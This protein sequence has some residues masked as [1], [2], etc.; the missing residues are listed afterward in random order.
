MDSRAAIRRWKCFLP[1]RQKSVGSE[2]FSCCFSFSE[3]ALCSG[4]DTRGH[5]LRA[6]GSTVSGH[7]ARAREDRRET[8][9]RCHRPDNPIPIGPSHVRWRFRRALL[10]CDA[11]WRFRPATGAKPRAPPGCFHRG[12]VPGRERGRATGFRSRVRRKR[13][14]KRSCASWSRSLPMS[15]RKCRWHASTGMGSVS[16]FTSDWEASAMARPKSRMMAQG[17]PKRNTTSRSRGRMA[18][19]RSVG[20]FH[21]PSTH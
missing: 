12:N 7:T 3:S 4:N 11:P 19:A 17:G 10:V 15:L 1:R 9:V 13:A 14:R 21:A 2:F 20:T 5:L 18:S 8:P 16:C 6:N